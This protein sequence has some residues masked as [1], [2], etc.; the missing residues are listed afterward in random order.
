MIYQ[1]FLLLCIVSIVLVLI[2]SKRK[3]EP[4]VLGVIGLLVGYISEVNGV[5]TGKWNYDNVD[6]LWS[7]SGVPIEIL[8]GYFTGMFL[9]GFLIFW[10]YNISD[11]HDRMKLV[12]FTFPMIGIFLVIYFIIHRDLDITLVFAF[13]GIGGLAMSK[14]KS[15]PLILGLLAFVGDVI[16]EGIL[17]Y[18]TEYYPGG[19][20]PGIAL[21]FMFTAMFIGGI[22]T[23]WDCKPGEN[24]C[25]LERDSKTIK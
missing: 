12:T 16:V 1:G 23:S 8:M 7:I 25:F 4:F 9:M 22:L 3:I 2:F 6:T 17:T 19:W 20:Q 21:A 5:M 18:H 10:I 11:E 13:L 14:R 24:F 15:I